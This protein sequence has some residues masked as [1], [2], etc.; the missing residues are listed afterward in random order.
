MILAPTEIAYSFHALIKI[1]KIAAYCSTIVWNE[2]LV[3]DS[4][5]EMETRTID[6]DASTSPGRDNMNVISEKI[7]NPIVVGI[8]GFI[9][10]VIIGLVILGWWLWPVKWTNASPEH[11]S[12][13][14]QEEYT[15]MAVEAFGQNSD[16]QKAQDRYEALGKGGE[17]A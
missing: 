12:T 6:Q 3:E 1:E 10:G 5:Y 15:R 16:V 9:I 14:W 13:E 7:K 11:L 8:I 4:F 2:Y 17:A